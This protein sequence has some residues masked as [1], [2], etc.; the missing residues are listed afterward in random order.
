[1]YSPRTL[2]GCTL[3]S[4]HAAILAQ[5]NAERKTKSTNTQQC[6]YDSSYVTLLNNAYMLYGT[7]YSVMPR[8]YY[9]TLLTL[10]SFAN[11]AAAQ[12]G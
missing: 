1:M 7:M 2:K 6:L 4:A 11:A 10:L 12:L 9:S 8:Q 5:D 3:H